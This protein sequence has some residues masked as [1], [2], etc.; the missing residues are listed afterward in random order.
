MPGP[1]VALLLILAHHD[2]DY[3]IIVTCDQ[4]ERSG[5]IVHFDGIA[6][7]H[8]LSHDFHEQWAA[9]VPFDVQVVATGAGLC[10]LRKWVGFF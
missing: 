9:V 3:R 5:L 1:D 8:V 2:T 10:P 4:G 6:L 7:F